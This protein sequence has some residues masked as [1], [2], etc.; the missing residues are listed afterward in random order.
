MRE[1]QKTLSE[2][3]WRGLGFRMVNI[4]NQTQYHLLFGTKHPLGMLKMKGAMWNVAPDGNFQY[5]DFSDP[6][7]LRLFTETMG[8]DYA[9]ELA[10]LIWQNRRGGTIAKKELLDNETAYHPTAIEKHLT[11][12]LRIMEY[13]AQPSRV[14]AVT[15]SD[16]TPRRARPYPD[17]CTIQFAA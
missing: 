6:S 4:H 10:E 11:R 9:Q 2:R 12:A 7:Q 14:L 5:S 15:K 8:E 1:Y 13:E 17:G 16:G 3:G